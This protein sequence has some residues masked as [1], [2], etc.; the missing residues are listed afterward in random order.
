MAPIGTPPPSPLASA[1]TFGNDAVLLT[2]EERTET[3]DARLDFVEHEQKSVRVR[4]RAKLPQESR[5]SGQHAAFSLNELEHDRRD[6]RTE[7]AARRFEI[8]VGDVRHAAERSETVLV[9]VLAGRGERA[10]RA[11]VKRI[12]ERDDAVAILLAAR[13]EMA[14]HELERRLDGFGARVTEKGAIHA[15]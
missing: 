9:L 13:V 8:A 15:R 14:T 10:E 5:R 12:V 3:A 4:E 7:C 1:T 6:V 2:G 11:A